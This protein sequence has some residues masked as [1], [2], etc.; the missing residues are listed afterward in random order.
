MHR[1]HLQNSPERYGFDYS[2]ESD[3]AD[4]RTVL[5]TAPMVLGRM[6]FRQYLV[7]RFFENFVGGSKRVSALSWLGFG[8]H[9]VHKEN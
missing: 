9:R 5:D 6:V 2:I 4:L 1:C 3:T 7:L 8:N